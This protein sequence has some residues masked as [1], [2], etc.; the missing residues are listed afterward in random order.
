MDRIVAF[1]EAAREELPIFS[2]QR[3]TRYLRF[4]HADYSKGAALGELSRLLG[5]SREEV[6]SLRRSS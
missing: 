5:I 4:C 6:F 1:I 3:N 2:F